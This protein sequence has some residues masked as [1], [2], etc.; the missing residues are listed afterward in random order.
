MYRISSDDV[1]VI[2]DK[3]SGSGLSGPNTLERSQTVHE[4]LMDDFEEMER[5]FMEEEF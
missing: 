3:E 2:E 1:D 4:S 5:K